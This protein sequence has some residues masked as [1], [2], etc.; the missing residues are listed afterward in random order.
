VNVS[1]STDLVEP[2]VSPASWA[3]IAVGDK[4]VVVGMA[5]ATGTVDASAVIVPL[6]QETGTITT[7]PGTTAP[8]SF[9]I[10]SA[11]GAPVASAAVGGAPASTTGSTVTVNV[12]TATKL[13][14]PGQAGAGLGAFLVGDRVTV[15]GTQDGPGV[16]DA[17]SVL[18]PA[19]QEEGTVATLPSSTTAP[20][21]FTV[22]VDGR[23]PLNRGIA[24]P[25]QASQGQGGQ[26]QGGQGQG[27]NGGADGTQT[28]TVNVTSATVFPQP[29]QARGQGGQG[30]Q[31]QGQGGQGQG[32]QGQGGQGQGGQGQGQGS[33]NTGSQNT[34][35]QNTGSLADLAVGDEVIVMGTQGGQGIIDATAVVIVPQGEGHRHGHQ[36]QGGPGQGGQGQGQGQGGQGQPGRPNR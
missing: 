25:V 9:T 36:G 31:G 1:T 12:S 2:G 22:T 3:D 14:E 29:G 8:T 4:V 17:L 27:G 26:G 18:L 23:G 24:G 6:A 34:G 13:R 10:V 5:D 21:S 16:V 32:G 28:V 11:A 20:T 35:S 19:V 33:Q 7:A 30:G 15:M